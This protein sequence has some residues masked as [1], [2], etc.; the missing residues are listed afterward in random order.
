MDEKNQS[1]IL[2]GVD[3]LRLE[4]V[5]IPEPGDDEVLIRMK[6]IGICGSDVHYWKH[7]RIGDFIVNE[8]MVLGHESAGQIVKI[9]ANVTDLEVGD[10]VALE[11]GVPCYY[12]DQ[13]LSGRYNLCKDVKFLATPPIHGSMQT[14]VT[15]SAN[16]CF[17]LPD[18]MTYDQG[19]M[20]EPLSVGL[21]AI[22][23]GG[24]TLGDTVFISGAG[25]IGLMCLIAAKAAGASI[26]IISD[27]VAERLDVAEQLGATHIFQIGKDDQVKSVDVAVKKG[28]LPE[29][30]IS[31]ECS[32]AGVAVTS[33]INCT[34]SGGKIVIVG[35]G[36]PEIK[37]PLV[38]A[39]CREVDI[40]GVFRY[41]NT[42][43]QA[44][45]LLASGQI[46][47]SPIITH[48]FDIENMIEAFNV[49]ANGTDGDNISIKVVVTL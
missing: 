21:Y 39:A 48:H 8:P 29:P 22:K 32:G 6:A 9:G 11:P 1:A 27:L 45:A 3:D 17:K 26:I 5:D 19:A 41:A 24:V 25:P 28:I 2:Y 44:R 12:C 35:M 46:D 42:Y 31:I 33:C 16:F 34:K 13:C 38:S 49:S 40:I 43:A 10:K 14:Y 23:R 18:N 36:P 20:M 4:E 47:V 37:I 30:T 7:G 15:H